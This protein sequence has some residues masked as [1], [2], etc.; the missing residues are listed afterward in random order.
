MNAVEIKNRIEALQNRAAK[1]VVTSDN[2]RNVQ[3][4]VDVI[5]SHMMS[6][7]EILSDVRPERQADVLNEFNEELDDTEKT[8]VWH[9]TKWGVA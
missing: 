8:L 5:D 1:I 2:K 4:I 3:G 9:E 6:L 7:E